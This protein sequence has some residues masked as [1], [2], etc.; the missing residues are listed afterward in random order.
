[1]KSIGYK[2]FDSIIDESYDNELNDEIR[3]MKAFKEVK[4]ICS[5]NINHIKNLSQK[6]NSVLEFNYNHMQKRIDQMPVDLEEKI[7]GTNI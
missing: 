4:R 7:N 5:M 1:M 6:V 3:F 2:T